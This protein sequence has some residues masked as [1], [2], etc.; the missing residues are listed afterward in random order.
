MPHTL[1]ACEC[2]RGTKGQRVRLPLLPAYPS[3]T[4]FWHSQEHMALRVSL[5]YVCTKVSW[6]KFDLWRWSFLPREHT[7]THIQI[8][9]YHFLIILEEAVPSSPTAWQQLSMLLLLVMTPPFFFFALQSCANISHEMELIWLLARHV[10][11]LNHFPEFWSLWVW[12]E[13]R[14]SD[15]PLKSKVRFQHW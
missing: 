4:A 12:R 2:K 11:C 5:H 14:H 3:P 6:S 1:G 8:L 7:H 15:Y 9:G 10:S 13:A